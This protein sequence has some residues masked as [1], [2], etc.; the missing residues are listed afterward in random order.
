MSTAALAAG[1]LVS[2]TAVQALPQLNMR[3]LCSLSASFPKPA[4]P[5]NEF[6]LLLRGGGGNQG[7]VQTIHSAI[8]VSAC[9]WN[10]P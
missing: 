2:L 7:A 3:S 5:M 10:A 4:V 6:P 9:V 8:K 1:L